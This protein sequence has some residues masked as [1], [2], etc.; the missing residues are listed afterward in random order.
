M[1]KL[2]SSQTDNVTSVVGYCVALFVFVF[3]FVLGVKSR[4][5]T[6]Y[7]HTHRHTERRLVVYQM[8][9]QSGKNVAS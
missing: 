6:T 4:S 3:V 5:S 9:G 1:T 2:I 7:K 8:V